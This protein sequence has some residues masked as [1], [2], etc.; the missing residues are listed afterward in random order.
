M[1]KVITANL[2]EVAEKA[3]QKYEDKKQHSIKERIEKLQLEQI[4]DMLNNGATQQIIADTLAQSK[5]TISYRI[6]VIKQDFPY[7]LEKSKSQKILSSQKYDNDND[8]IEREEERGAATPPAITENSEIQ[9]KAEKT[10]KVETKAQ[11]EPRRLE[12]TTINYWDRSESGVIGEID[13]EKDLI[14]YLEIL[15]GDQLTSKV[16]SQL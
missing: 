4:A 15:F 9:K 8:K 12:E 3:N 1:V 10:E 14:A 13:N 2:R 16:K 7:L 6:G 11:E 5:Q